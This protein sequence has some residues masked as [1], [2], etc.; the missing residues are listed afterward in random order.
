MPTNLSWRANYPGLPAPVSNRTHCIA[1][2]DWSSQP[3]T[4][5]ANGMRLDGNYYYWPGSWVQDR[6]GF[7]TGSGMPM[8]FAD[9]DGTMIDVY[10][11]TTQMTDESNQSFPGTINALLDKAVGTEGYYGAFNANFHTDASTEPESNALVASAHSHNVPIVSGK[12]MTSW[13]DGRNASSYSAI[14][15]SANTL[16]FTV[17][18]GTGAT[19]LTGMVPLAG[20]NGTQLTGLT[21]AGSAVAFNNVTIKGL[22]Y[23]QFPAAAGTYAATYGAPAAAM[24]I[25]EAAADVAATPDLDVATLTW[26]TPA[27][28]SSEVAIGT[29]KSA[30]A[31]KTV[32]KGAAKKHRLVL[33]RLKAATTYYY[34][35]TSTDLKGRT[36]SWPA[37]DKDPAS[38]TTPGVDT[39]KPTIT[40]ASASALPDGTALVSG[41]PTSRARPSSGWAR[42][43]TSWS[44]SASSSISPPTTSSC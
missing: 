33:K 41:R 35:L 28:A 3:K 34:R 2:S 43:R 11:A 25:T 19:G 38:F 8:R 42:V 31:E 21:R 5:L 44:R 32:T 13:L 10:Q 24:A 17:K 27:T 37:A 26:A 7:M 15:W 1:F 22:D 29:A 20:P 23:A 16:S 30:L 12:Q 39:K 14:G 4:E 40:D 18:V 6:P 36:V 9:T